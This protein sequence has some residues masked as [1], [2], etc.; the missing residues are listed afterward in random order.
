MSAFGAHELEEHGKTVLDAI[1]FY[2]A[3]L[4]R[5]DASIPTAEAI[6]KLLEARAGQGRSARYLNDVRVRLRRFARSFGEQP[7]AAI[8]A[9]DIEA[10]LDGLKVGPVTRNTTRQRLSVLFSFA[11]KRGWLTESPVPNVEKSKEPNQAV[12]I[13]TPEQ[14]SV[15]LHSCDDRTR[16]YWALLLFAGLRPDSEAARPVGEKEYRLHWEKVDIE[17]R[18]IF[19]GGDGK[20]GNRVVPMSDNLA[21][22]LAPY[23]GRTGPVAPPALR[24]LLRADRARIGYGPPDP[25]GICHDV[26]M[27]I[28]QPWH[29]D[30]PRHSYGSYMMATHEDVGKVATWMGNSIAVVKRNYWKRVRPRDAAAYWAIMP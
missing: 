14:A 2:V 13:F 3:H 17:E 22:W 21:A 8:T 24:K 25:F 27:A 5:L 1:K 15:L 18:H 28:A 12:H 20:T 23:A 10:W 16:P 30:L 19:V 26:P 11:K 6:A 9:P 7:I 29:E 4:K